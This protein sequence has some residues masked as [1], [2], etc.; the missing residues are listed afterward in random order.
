[1]PP[2]IWSRLHGSGGAGSHRARRGPVGHGELRRVMAVEV[3][4]GVVGSGGLG[5]MRSSTFG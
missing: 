1:M 3:G 5:E 4:L 2:S